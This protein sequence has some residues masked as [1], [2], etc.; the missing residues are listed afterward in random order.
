MFKKAGANKVGEGRKKLG[1]D[2]ENEI[3]NAIEET[4]K[5]S[6]YVKSIPGAE[7][8]NFTRKV[9]DSIDFS[10]RKFILRQAQVD[11]LIL[12]EGIEALS[13]SIGDVGLINPIYLQMKEDLQSYRIVS[14]YRRSTAI[15]LGFEKNPE[16][17]VHG[18]IIIIPSTVH[19]DNLE[20]LN[21]NEN[22]HRDDLKVLELAYRL[23]VYCKKNSAKLE[24][25]ASYYNL[26]TSHGKKLSTALNYHQEIK[27]I[28]DDIGINKAS[29]LNTLVKHMKKDYTV[30]EIVDAYKDKTTKEMREAL[31]GYK[32]QVPKDSMEV[33]RTK[34]YSTFKIN[35]QLSDDQYQEIQSM[36][37]SWLEENIG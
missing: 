6:R 24:E 3:K 14:G 15:K 5:H 36:I 31:K 17:K 29:E 7:M 12:D 1:Q 30:Q 23:H 18:K 21:V 34:K 26:S 10:D 13:E 22:S 19:E 32:N 9:F 27:V 20:V 16:F 35:K 8:E 4:E 2:R 33:K 28:L 37:S 11:E 25:A